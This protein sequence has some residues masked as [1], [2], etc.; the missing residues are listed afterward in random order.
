MKLGLSL[1]LHGPRGATAAFDPATL[2]LTGWWRASYAGAPWAATASAGTSLANGGL[3]TN[4]D[5]PTVGTTQNGYAPA[6]FNGSGNN[7]RN[8]TDI[9]SFATTTAS[10]IVALFRADTAAAPT[11]NIYDD[12]SLFIDA[13]ADYGLSFT[14]SGVGGFATA[15]VYKSK[16]VACATGAYHL[17]MMR[18]N[19][20]N[21]GMTLDSAAEVTSVCGTLTALSGNIDTGRGY[22]AAHFFDGRILELMIAGVALSDGDYANIRGYVNTRYGLAL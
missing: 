3:T 14:T 11:G 17:V 20:V 13:N 9:T 8:V 21:L 18:H 1:D 12:A 4:S 2:A 10:T 22:G 16:Y 7:L 15:G 5:D 19:G 6:D